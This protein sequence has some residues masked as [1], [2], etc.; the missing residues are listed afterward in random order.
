MP[1]PHVPSKALLSTLRNST[2]AS[3][4]T[5]C[6]RTTC[7]QLRWESTEQRQLGEGKSFKGQLYESTAVRLERERREQARFSKVRNEGAGGR[8]MALSFGTVKPV[9]K[10]ALQTSANY[11][12]CS[13]A[14]CKLWILLS[15]DTECASSVNNLDRPSSYHRRTET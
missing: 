2:R 8:N 6:F 15:R 13:I 9:P 4:A 14:C 10:E 11:M 7:R 3:R 1:F 5:P 12:F